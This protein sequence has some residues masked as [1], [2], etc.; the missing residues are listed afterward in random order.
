MTDSYIKQP[1][2]IHKLFAKYG[3]DDFL[4]GHWTRECPTKPGYYPVEGVSC[5]DPVG[6]VP[7]K[8]VIAYNNQ[9]QLKLSQTWG[10]WWWSE[11]LPML[12]PTPDT[13][14]TPHR[15]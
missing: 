11:P 4:C 14:C 12:P 10:G 7:S 1:M 9:G 6:I 13:D 5:G 2:A 3:W 15:S 8:T